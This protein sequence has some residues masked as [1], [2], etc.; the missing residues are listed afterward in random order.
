M[1]HSSAINAESPLTGTLS[2][3]GPGGAYMANGDKSLWPYSTRAALLAIPVIWLT[4]LLV[5][6]FLRLFLAWTE[7]I[8]GNILIAILIAGLVPLALRI[9]DHVVGARAILKIKGVELD[10]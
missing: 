4:L 5:F 8:S 2:L 7:A 1:D 10:F 3:F 6:I 9:V